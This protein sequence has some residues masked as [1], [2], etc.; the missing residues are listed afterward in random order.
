[1]NATTTDSLR[2]VVQANIQPYAEFVRKTLGGHPLAQYRTI[3]NRPTAPEYIIPGFISIGM[4]NIS[5]GAG[6]GKTTTLV[7]LALTAAGIHRKGD[8]LAPKRWRHVVYITEDSPQ[9]ERIITGMV[10]YADMGLSMDLIN[11]RFH[12][13]DAARMPVDQVVEVADVYREQFTRSVDSHEL[14]PLVV[15]DTRNAAFELDNE[16]DNAQA[17]KVVASLK[18]RFGDMPVW[19]VSHVAKAANSDDGQSS[20]GAG[21]WDADVNQTLFL[22]KEKRTGH[23]FIQ[24]GKPRFEPK[25]SQIRIESHIRTIQAFDRF[26]DEHTVALR[27]NTL[28]PVEEMGRD[29]IEQARQQAE[30]EE[31]TAV[32]TAI[33]EAV[34]SAWAARMPLSKSAVRG[35]VRKNGAAVGSVVEVL[36]DEGWLYQVEIPAAVRSNP[37]RKSYLVR[38]TEAERRDLED[39]VL[40]ADKMVIPKA[41]KKVQ[42]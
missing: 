19:V 11:E 14:P 22:T 42:E 32:R 26:G 10:R 31:R 39:G 18:Q 7:P 27:W 17:S 21:A 24:I 23:R 41:W 34:E 38:L 25:W 33:L 4:V 5:G 30:D 40:P 3:S 20:R 8:Q 9:V 12:L 13:V 29:A 36:L 15:F 2:E 37:N 6:V 16:N 35:K 1:M 28:E